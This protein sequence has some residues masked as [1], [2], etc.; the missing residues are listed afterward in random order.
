MFNRFATVLNS[1]D[2]VMK[3]DRMVVDSD[4]DS[5]LLCF[6]SFTVS[7]LL[8]INSPSPAD[9]PQFHTAHF[10][11]PVSL[12]HASLDSNSRIQMEQK[13]EVVSCSQSP[14]C[15]GVNSAV[16]TS[17]SHPPSLR[18]KAAAEGWNPDNASFAPRD[19]MQ[20]MRSAYIARC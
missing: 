18:A 7:P 20:A 13:Q 8:S 11:T 9:P 10:I 5:T 6:V 1:W 19:Q 15:A 2:V 16:N 12:H 14:S 3:D 17:H 4:S